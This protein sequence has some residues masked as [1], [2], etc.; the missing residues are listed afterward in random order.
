MSCYLRI[1]W[2]DRQSHELGGISLE[3]GS[4]KR[5]FGSTEG[6]GDCIFISA[7]DWI[8]NIRLMFS[9][10]DSNWDDRN[11]R[12]GEYVHMQ[13]SF[14]NGIVVSPSLSCLFWGPT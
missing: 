4:V 12:I 1:Y 10:T 6:I 3:I 9:Q 5:V 8:Q 7:G 11:C 2:A 13:D 14:I